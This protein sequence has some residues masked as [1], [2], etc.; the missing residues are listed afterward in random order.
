MRSNH[1]ISVGIW[2]L[3][4]RYHTK[5]FEQIV[6]VTLPSNEILA[7]LCVVFLF[8]S[9]QHTNNGVASRGCRWGKVVLAKNL[10]AEEVVGKGFLIL[11]K[12]WCWSWTILNSFDIFH[13]AT[14]YALRFT[15]LK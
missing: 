13:P 12:M 7:S 3:P 2:I 14:L 9:L 6:I 5:L 11:M 4:Y 10:V 8:S 1:A 15:D